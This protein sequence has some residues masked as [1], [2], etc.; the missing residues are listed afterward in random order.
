ME[1]YKSGANRN[2]LSMELLDFESLI[3]SDNP[4][5]AIDGSKFRAS[6]NS[7]AYWTKKKLADK[8]EWKQKKAEC[9]PGA[10]NQ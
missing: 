8:R 7:N 9:L 1:R 4:V 6:N 3:A 10:V 5:R 2:Q